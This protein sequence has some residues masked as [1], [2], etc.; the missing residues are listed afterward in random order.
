M[1]LTRRAGVMPGR[2]VGRGRLRKATRFLGIPAHVA[3][4][5]P[6]ADVQRRVELSR[7]TDCVFTQSP[8]KDHALPE[9]AMDELAALA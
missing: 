9:A 6:R 4:P 1:T 2:G 8:P 3:R 7:A 5:R